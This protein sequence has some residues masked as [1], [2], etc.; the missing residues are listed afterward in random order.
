LEHPATYISF[1]HTTGGYW[2]AE[3]V[4]SHWKKWVCTEFLQQLKIFIAL[5]Q[6]L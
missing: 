5:G 3:H 1:K 2:D 6:I 4:M